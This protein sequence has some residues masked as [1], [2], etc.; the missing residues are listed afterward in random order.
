MCF[1]LGH[2]IVSTENLA[3]WPN[4]MSLLLGQEPFSNSYSK[5]LWAVGNRLSRRSGLMPPDVAA[6]PHVSVGSYQAVA[7]LFA[8]QGFRLE[9]SFGVHILPLPA[10]FLRW[11]SRRGRPPF[12]VHD[13][14]LP[15]AG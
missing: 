8:R 3:A 12:D 4:I 14:H 10:R 2:A 5:R 15:Q 7:D 9:S 6:Y 13:A 11:L 1:V